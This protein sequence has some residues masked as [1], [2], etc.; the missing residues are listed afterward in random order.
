[1]A[2]FK[3]NLLIEIENYKVDDMRCRELNDPDR[4][5]APGWLIGDNARDRPCGDARKARRFKN[6]D[7]AAAF[8]YQK[9][10]KQKKWRFTLLYETGNFKQPVSSLDE[11]LAI[12]AQQE[13]DANEQK[14]IQKESRDRDMPEL[15]RLEEK[16][17]WKLGV[18]LAMF[19]G[20]IRNDGVEAAK[21]Q[22]STS[23]F[24]RLKKLLKEAGVEV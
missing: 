22:G 1:M 4:F 6:Y 7:E 2:D 19:L 17:G 5:W 10:K 23:T 15:D 11:I 24:Y 8:I 20:T 13:A 9:Q 18:Q 21:A 3:G 16:Y 12:D 14:R